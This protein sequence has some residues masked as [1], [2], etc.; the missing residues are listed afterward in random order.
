M[1]KLPAKVNRCPLAQ[2]N[3]TFPFEVRQ[4]NFGLGRKATHRAVFTVRPDM[5]LVLRVRHLAQ[6]ELTLDDL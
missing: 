2:E 4:L 3:G 1:T 6:N 5:I